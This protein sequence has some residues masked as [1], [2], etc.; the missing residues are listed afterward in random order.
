MRTVAAVVTLFASVLFSVSASAQNAEEKSYKAKC[1]SC[2][3]A[4]GR[5]ATPY[6]KA[7]KARDFCSDEVKKEA[8]DEWSTIINKGKNKMPAYDKKLAHAEGKG[9][10][11]YIGSLCK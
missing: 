1:A 5:G 4:D 3:G 8:D 9:I 7:A 10:V 6:G 2:Q 11:D